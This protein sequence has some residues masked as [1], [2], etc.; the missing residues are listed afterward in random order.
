MPDITLGEFEQV[1][2]LALVRLGPDAYGMS[3][4]EAIVDRTGR[5]VS[6]GAVYK[7]L[8]RLEAKGL[9]AGRIGSPT[10]ER[11]G[12]RKKH[13]RLLA[14]GERSLKRSLAA[15]RRLTDGLAADLRV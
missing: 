3:L 5:E 10:A 6:L 12:R 1:V 2:L 15:L 9:I 13:Y 14:T 7:T 8:E 4:Y 11:G